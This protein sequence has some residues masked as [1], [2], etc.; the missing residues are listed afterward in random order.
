MPIH[1]A[2]PAFNTTPVTIAD[3]Q[4]VEPTERSMPPVMIT[5][6]IPMATMATKAKFRVTLKRFCGVAKASVANDRITA[7]SSAAASTQNACRL[8]TCASRPWLRASIARC[9]SLEVESF[10]GGSGGGD[11]AG[12]EPGHLF[13]TGGGDRLVGDL[14]AAAQDDDAIGHREHVGHA[15]ADEHDGDPLLAQSA[16]QVEYLGDLAHG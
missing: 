12:D 6:V 2:C 1:A 13:R 9:S 14:G 7:A 11:R 16:H 15:V 3:R 8:S 4:S 5:I 10:I